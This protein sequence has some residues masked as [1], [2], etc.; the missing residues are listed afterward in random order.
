MP[1]PSVWGPPIWTLFHCLAEKIHPDAYTHLSSALLNQ[2]K[3]ICK[4][5][6]C[7]TC[8]QDA[9]KF[10][11]GININNYKSKE[12]FK[13][14][15]Y[16]F[17]NWVNRKTGK[18]VFN[19]SDMDK[20]TNMNLINVINKFIEVYHTNGN[21]KL[22]TDSFQRQFIIKNFMTWIKTNNRAFYVPAIQKPLENKLIEKSNED[23]SATNPETVVPK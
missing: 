8:T 20:Y 5:L 17:H 13:K 2:I 4:A 6:P 11:S 18:N 12:D 1:P 7:P 19:Y 21:M 15:F 10:L 23:S 3:Q 22:L 14:L 16:I 9:T